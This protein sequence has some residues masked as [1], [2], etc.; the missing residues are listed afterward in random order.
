M[1]K[2]KLNGE[3]VTK[4]SLQCLREKKKKSGKQVR[5]PAYCIFY[6]FL[7]QSLKIKCSVR[8][9]GKADAERRY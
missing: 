2:N 4:E 7:F 3:S 9:L 5:E 8:H 6:V 1:D